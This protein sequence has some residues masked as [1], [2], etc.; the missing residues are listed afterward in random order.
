MAKTAQSPFRSFAFKALVT[1]AS[2]YAGSYP[3]LIVTIFATTDGFEYIL[4]WVNN[5]KYFMIP[6]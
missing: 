5:S 6:N 3:M 4:V 2:S 1:F